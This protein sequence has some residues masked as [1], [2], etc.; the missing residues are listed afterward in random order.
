MVHLQDCDV[1]CFDYGWTNEEWAFAIESY[2]VKVAHFY[3]TPIG[4]AV[5]VVVN[6]EPRIVHL[7]KVGVKPPFRKR[8]AGRLLIHEATTFARVQGLNEIEAV[9]PEMLCSPGE[10]QD[11]T[12]WLLKVGFLGTGVIR[13]YIQNMGVKEDGYKFKLRF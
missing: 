13:N 1:K 12:G 8:K 2:S 6:D 9:V 11:I 5:F 3:G 4:F 10:P 7:F